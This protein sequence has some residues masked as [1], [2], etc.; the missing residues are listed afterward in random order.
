MRRWTLARRVTALVGLGALFIVTALVVLVVVTARNEAAVDDLLNR[1]GPSRRGA[2]ELL[3]TLVEEQ[4]SVRGYALTGDFA[5]RL[6][7]QAAVT[8]QDDDVRGLRALLTEDDADISA[9]L[10]RVLAEADRWRATGAAPLL[11]DVV[12]QGPRPAADAAYRAEED[13][14]GPVLT[15]AHALVATLDRRRDAAT[16]GL[17]TYRRTE[18]IALFFGAA[19]AV[20]AGTGTLLL[21][22]RW[23]TN[24]IDRLAADARKVADG[25]HN[26]QVGVP[27]GPPELT[28]VADDVERMRS[29]IVNELAEL[30]ASQQE[31]RETRD[32]LQS[33]AIDLMRSNRDLEQF[34][35]V[36]SHD[37]QEPL[38]KVAGFCQLLQR[39]YAG[40]L[41]ERAEQYIEFAVDGAQRMQRLISELLAFSR[42]GRSDRAMAD[43]SLT[44]VAADALRDLASAGDLTSGA[45]LADARVVVGE[46]PRVRGDAVLLRQLFTNLIGNAVKFHRV[47]T[48]AEVHVEA[49]RDAVGWQ[50]SVADN[51]IGI[52]PEFEDKIFVLFQRLHGREA[53]P[54]TGIG[55]ALAK[56][57]VEYHGGRIW[58]DTGRRDGTTIR[59]SLPSAEPSTSHEPTDERDDMS[60]TP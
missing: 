50:I 33:Q 15:S 14:F 38:R 9:Q 10:D 55:L 56:R 25:D 30:A 58:L 26:H 54:G 12:R 34:A 39:R 19:V 41:D 11:D 31:L 46:L 23:V 21:L 57:I 44:E 47:D 7:Y 8:H 42:V 49:H 27:P 40:Q 51:G 2:A 45:E 37:L 24:P 59:F 3:T 52:P 17:S 29:R 60:S 6:A 43:V 48:P 16:A 1:V 28:A 20:A 36:A 35:Y 13:L 5:R 53:Y 4:N 32:R 18:L 22:R